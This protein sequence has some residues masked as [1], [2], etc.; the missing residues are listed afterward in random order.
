MRPAFKP[1]LQ[2]VIVGCVGMAVPERVDDVRL[3]ERCRENGRPLLIDSAE[4]RIMIVLVFARRD[5]V[6][7]AEQIVLTRAVVARGGIGLCDI[8]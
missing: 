8:R 5:V 7:E 6:A 4:G 2:I 3:S 1:E